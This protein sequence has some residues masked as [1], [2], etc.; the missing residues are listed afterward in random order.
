MKRKGFTLIELLV[1]VAIIGILAAV[2]LSSLSTARVKA[3]NARAQSELVQMRTISA[4]AQINGDRTLLAM[5]G[6]VVAGTYDHCPTGTDLGTL[7]VSH[8]C[9][10]TWRAAIDTITSYFNDSDAEGF[11]E[12]VWGAPYL[13]AENEDRDLM[14][15]CV[16]DTITSAGADGIAFTADDIT[17]VIPFESCG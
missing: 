8:A 5:T 4:G 13:L 16:S 3:Q 12:D 15:P 9:V 17:V 11:Y 7:S 10:T 1:V 6:S 2:V 14:T